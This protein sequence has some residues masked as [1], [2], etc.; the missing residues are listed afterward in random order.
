LS[1]SEIKSFAKTTFKFTL[2]DAALKQMFAL[3]GADKG[4][5]KDDFQRLKVMIGC[6]R[7][8]EKD[9]ARK[10][11]RLEKE[12][13]IEGMKKEAK[14]QIAKALEAILASEELVKKADGTA[15]PAFSKAS[16]TEA[17]VVFEEADE[18]DKLVAEAKEDIEKTRETVKSLAEDIEEEIKTWALIEIRMLEA[19]MKN[20]DA[21]TSKVTATAAKMRDIAKRKEL[22]EL[23]VLEGQ[24][25]DIMRYHQRE[26]KLSKEKLFDLFDAD[27]D[28][29]ISETEF[30]K[31]FDGCKRP[32][33][34]KVEKK[35]GE[36]EAD[37]GEDELEPTPKPEGLSKVFKSLDEDDEGFLSKGRFGMIMISVMKVVAEATLSKE[38]AAGS[39]AVRQLDKGE[40]VEVVEG[41]VE[42]GKLK[43]AKVVAIK[44]GTEGYV[45]VSD[46]AGAVFLREGGK[47]FKVVKETIL[48]E[49]FDLED[50]A[51]KEQAP[52]KKVATRKLKVGELVEVREYPK[53]E[54]KSGLTR[55][56]CK[57][58]TD[59][60]LGWATTL[61]NAGAVFLE[62]A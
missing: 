10:K 2:S 62:V 57:A 28:G 26:E 40:V 25:L 49:S 42:E 48:T 16:K 21:R 13:L 31:F 33:K 37:G 24:T 18:L 32:P 4:V 60:R 55:M 8:M 46:D 27:K 41:P 20:W 45:T 61:G 19:R 47:I 17:S 22:A 11:E 7:E 9:A 59:G 5:K 38:L 58:K 50:D 35:E 44:D 23:A 1:K 30:V 43:R 39:D 34:A 6:A 53:K 12:A 3:L 52:E 29:K 54:E 14:E 51:P 36:A 15:T 56:K